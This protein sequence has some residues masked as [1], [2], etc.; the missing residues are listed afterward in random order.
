MDAFGGVEDDRYTLPLNRLDA[1]GS[2]SGSSNRW[3][4]KREIELPLGNARTE[5]IGAS[6]G[7]DMAE[8]RVLHPVCIAIHAPEHAVGQ[9]EIGHE[10]DELQALAASVAPGH[11][12]AQHE[13]LRLELLLVDAFHMGILRRI[14]QLG[15]GLRV[16][17]DHAVSLCLT[18]A[19]EPV[20]K[21]DEA[22]DER[23]AAACHW[24][25]GN[26]SRFHRS[27]AVRI[28]DA[29]AKTR[30]VAR[31]PVAKQACCLVEREM[32]PHACLQQL[33]SVEHV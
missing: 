16:T 22:L 24:A 17:T 2:L 29:I 12:A 15:V 26:D 4:N 20:A 1:L 13:A 14:L 32:R 7:L 18:Q 6:L 31:V 33:G 30:E 5:V 27:L 10:G 19:E 8:H 9:I 25:F 23:E 11:G 28:G 21:I 3:V